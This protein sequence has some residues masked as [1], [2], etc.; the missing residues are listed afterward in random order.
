LK[1]EKE[2]IAVEAAVEKTITAGKLT[3]DLGGKAGTTEV[4]DIILSYLK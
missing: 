3:A 4:T 2:A 1:L